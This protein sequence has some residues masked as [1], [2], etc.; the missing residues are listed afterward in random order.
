MG[1]S[2]QL[3][4]HF[5]QVYFGGNWTD[6]DLKSNLSTVDLKKATTKKS[7]FN[8]IAALTHHIGYFT[9]VQLKVLQGGPLEGSDAVSF[10][11]PPLNTESDWRQLVGQTLA[12]GL[13]LSEAIRAL[14]DAIWSE[15]F[16]EEKYGS[17]FTTILQYP[18]SR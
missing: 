8:T 5:K 9:A 18:P 2:T 12:N 15:P 11:H 17:Y 7:N 13:A 4:D 6:S 16:S 14:P 1:L 3:A 10:N